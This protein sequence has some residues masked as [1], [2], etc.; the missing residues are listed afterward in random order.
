MLHLRD[1]VASGY[2]GEVMSCHVRR[3]SS[4]VLQRQSD[5]TWQ[6]DRELGAN[7][8]TITFGHTIDALRMVV[9]DFSHV[10]TVVSTQAK[11]WYETDT[12]QMVDVTSPDN[13]LVSGRLHTGAVASAHIASNPWFNSGFLME[14]Y[15]SE[16]TL[17][18]T[19]DE[20]P[21][22]FGIRVQGAQ[23]NDNLQD[24]PSPPQ[25]TWVLEG[26]PGGAVYNVGQMYYEFG[27][28]IRGEDAC[29][30]DFDEAVRLHRFIDKV[31]QASDSGREVSVD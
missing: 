25:Y 10:S 24:L 19:S 15:G 6:R 8:L 13:I 9:G 16:G 3:I 14:I 4:G 22:H 5:R 20:T 28:A 11:H 2:V 29:H 7:T 27:R 21:N 17:V 26:M 23:G 12:E 18:A 1:L 31:Q 30:P